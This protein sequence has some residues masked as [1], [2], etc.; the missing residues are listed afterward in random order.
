MQR[1]HKEAWD[2]TRIG[3]GRTQNF[4]QMEGQEEKAEVREELEAVG[5]SRGGGS[6]YDGRFL[7]LLEKRQ[8]EIHI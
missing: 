5:R 3:G 4:E 7:G 6:G 1:Q 2:L 8:G